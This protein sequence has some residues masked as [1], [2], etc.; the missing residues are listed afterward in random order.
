VTLR[1]TFA[2]KI[3]ELISFG[4][5]RGVGLEE[6]IDELEMARDGLQAEIDDREGDAE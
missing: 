5:E 2:E 4:R 1:P 6:M 3:D